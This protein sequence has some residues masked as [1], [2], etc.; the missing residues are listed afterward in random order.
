MVV[1]IW[2]CQYC[3]MLIGPP[4]GNELNR[5]GSGYFRGML[6]A[7][8]KEP[9]G[10]LLELPGQEWIQLSECLQ[11]S[12][13]I[14]VQTPF[15]LSKSHMDQQCQ[16]P[17]RA[18]PCN[19]HLTTAKCYLTAE[20][21][22]LQGGAKF[23]FVASGDKRPYSAPAPVISL[24]LSSAKSTGAATQAP[25]REGKHR[26]PRLHVSEKKPRGSKERP[27]TLSS[28]IVPRRGT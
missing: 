18:E 14:Y 10:I 3:K 23:I 11:V 9:E 16:S 17:E 4:A 21:Q 24:C 20:S 13:R 26:C 15:G 2:N 12:T 27:A 28:S 22:I 6:A 1:S 8:L 7:A 19:S 25:T 5:L